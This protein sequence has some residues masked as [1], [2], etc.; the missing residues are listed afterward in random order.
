MSKKNFKADIATGADRFFSVYDALE[1]VA[2]VDIEDVQDILDTRSV[3]IEKNTKAI[4]DTSSVPGALNAEYIEGIKDVLHVPDVQSIQ[5]VQNTPHVH[6]GQYVQDTEDVQ[7]IRPAYYRIN[8]K[9]RGEHKDFLSDEAW[10]QRISITELLN[11][12]IAEYRE[13]VERQP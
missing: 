5:G 4:K 13:R 10:R 8:L 2:E 3:P 9:L 7:D 1:R 11:R 6:S 12:M